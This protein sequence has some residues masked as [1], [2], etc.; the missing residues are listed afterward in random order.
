MVVHNDQEHTEESPAQSYTYS[1]RIDMVLSRATAYI[2]RAP[3]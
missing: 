1:K 2:H 3:P